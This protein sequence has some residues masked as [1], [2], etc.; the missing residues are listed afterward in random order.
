MATASDAGWLQQLHFI[1]APGFGIPL[2]PR[3]T[4]LTDKQR[5]SEVSARVSRADAVG[6]C[7]CC[8]FCCCCRRRRSWRQA[9]RSNR[10]ERSRLVTIP[11]PTPYTTDRVRQYTDCLLYPILCSS[12]CPS[13]SVCSRVSA[14]PPRSA[15]T[16]RPSV[17]P[18]PTGRGRAAAAS[19]AHLMAAY[20]SIL[21]HPLLL[22]LRLQPTL[23]ADCRSVGQRITDPCT[24]GSQ[25]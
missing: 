11:R 18:A 14:S 12:V 22:M 7:C 8:C 16:D 17:P 1:V 23:A 24:S 5:V 20:V 6:C 2:R 15:A 9:I 25:P 21:L 4:L 19:G 13:V 10:S 3:C